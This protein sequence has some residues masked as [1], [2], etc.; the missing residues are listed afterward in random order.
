MT[1]PQAPVALIAD[2]YCK[3]HDS[4]VGHPEAPGRF[5]AVMTGLAEA[6][7]RPN[8]LRIDPKRPTAVDLQRVHT[9]EYLGAAE[10]EIKA[11]ES[12]LSTGDTNIGPH[13]WEAALR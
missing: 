12:Q 8:L 9:A 2:P 6:K 10:R 4:G 1:P 7:P 5:D 3:E 13:T 11:G